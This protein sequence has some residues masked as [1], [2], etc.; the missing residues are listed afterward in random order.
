MKALFEVGEEVYLRSIDQHELNCST[1]IEGMVTQED[2]AAILSDKYP[3]VRLCGH[4]LADQSDGY[5][6]YLRDLNPLS[7]D[8]IA[9]VDKCWM[10]VSLRKKHT[11]GEDFDTLMDK[12]KTGD[13]VEC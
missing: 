11:P 4:W 1:V 13:V 10:S 7:G 8:H 6:Y 12:L 9:G 3:G 2:H 5:A